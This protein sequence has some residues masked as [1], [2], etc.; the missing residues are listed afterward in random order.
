MHLLLIEPDKLQAGIYA[1]ALQHAGHTVTRACSAQAA[2]HAADEQ[3]PD[4]VILELQLPAHNGVEFL[5]E[6]RSYPEWL[7]IPVILHTFVPPQELTYA[8]TLEHELG[9]AQV[10]YKPKTSLHQLCTAVTTLVAM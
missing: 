1:E 8:A 5:Y 3:M 7:H 9:V 4:L 10:L 6:F 2:V